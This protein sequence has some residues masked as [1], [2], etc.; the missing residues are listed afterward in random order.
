[1]ANRVLLAV[2]ISWCLVAAV[3]LASAL[4]PHFVDAGPLMHVFPACPAFAAGHPCAL[5]GMT[6]A[7]I[8]IAQGD[9]Q[10]ALALNPN[11]VPLYRAFFANAFCSSGALAVYAA[12]RFTA[13]SRPATLNFHR[14]EQCKP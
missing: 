5:C 12:V 7:F 1:M 13:C 8:A 11:S 14:G 6:R 10:L 3:A 9:Y 2:L 4:A